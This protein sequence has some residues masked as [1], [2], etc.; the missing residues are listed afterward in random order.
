MNQHGIIDLTLWQMLAAYLL[1]AMVLFILRRQGIA[2]EREIILASVRATLQLIIAGYVLV[3]LIA[4]PAPWMIILLLCAMEAFAI[5][6]IIKKIKTP[7]TREFK[8]VIA[9]AMLVGSSACLFYF[10]LVIVGVDPW[11]D[12][13]FFIPISGMLIGNSMN[14]ISLAATLLVKGITEQRA[15]VEGALML[16]ATPQAAL[17]PIVNSAFEAAILPTVNT[18]LGLGIVFLPG[19]MTGQ[20]LSGTSPLIAIE[21][22]LAIMLGIL[23]STALS[24]ILML[25]RG[26][27]TFFNAHQQLRA[28]IS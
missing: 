18:L 13:Q 3:Y 24:V 16:G 15:Q 27:K 11:Y 7:L 20:I 12:P 6:T 23:G 19:M 5:H 22:Q 9:G 28:E 4:Q 17:K 21:Y 14:G 2:R 10:L 25:H 8:R 1:V 26:S